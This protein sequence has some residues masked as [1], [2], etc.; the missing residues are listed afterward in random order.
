MSGFGD[1]IGI[2][3]E[4]AV[5]NSL[6]LSSKVS[7]RNLGIAMERK[8]GVP[9]KAIYVDD[10]KV[11]KRVFG[12]YDPNMYSPYVLECLFNN[13]GG[14][15]VS[16]YGL[17]ITGDGCEPAEATI[18]TSSHDT[19]T[20]TYAT[21]VAPDTGVKQKDMFTAANIEAGDEFT[22]SM[23]TTDL[24]YT[25]VIGDTPQTVANS[26]KLL[27]EAEKV[28]NPAGDFAAVNPLYGTGCMYLEADVADT[29][30]VATS[31]AADA[32]VVGAPVF[33]LTAGRMGEEDPGDWGNDLSYSFYPKGADGGLAN[34]YMLKIFYEDVLVEMWS[35]ATFAELDAQ[36]R[37]RSEYVIMDEIDYDT[38]ITVDIISGDLSG[39]IYVA[40]VEAD[41]EPDY[42]EA[43]DPVGMAIFEG[44]DVQIIFCPEIQSS[45][46]ALDAETWCKEKRKFFLHNLPYLATETQ[47]QDFYNALFTPDRSFQSG[48][49]NWCEVDDGE[50]GRIWI[51]AIGY[52][53]G[54]G[55]IRLAGMNDGRVWTPPGGLETRAYGV[56]RF[57]HDTLSDTTISR[58]VKQ[59][60]C[61]VVK[62][63]KN[64]GYCLWSSRTYSNNPL[65]QSVHIQ[66]EENWLGA[67][68]LLR[69]QRY[70]QKLGQPSTLR[71]MRLDDLTF[72]QFIYN[73]GGIEQSISFDQAV[74][75][76][77][78][79]DPTDRKQVE[80]D[81]AWIPPECIEH[82][83]I[84]L[85]RNDGILVLK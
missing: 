83:H 19:Q 82:I 7:T 32:G 59:F 75:I 40:P 31:A 60:A 77:V 55:Y 27:V 10:L 15:G 80:M 58:Y 70:V 11:D 23:G 65:F 35:A 81:I 44:Y 53:V 13:L 48:I 39:G 46:F 20:F 67:E 72:M 14:Y 37:Q 18:T 73:Q 56:Y 25:A 63:I 66:L 49:L 85:G 4:T 28:A 45:D 6:N 42:D 30:F 79:V 34:E 61:N 78:T 24:T 57:T 2:T 38:D 54:A 84:K 36:I 50:G 33:T 52:A 8:R 62:Y 71:E 74:V 12:G 1:Q 3:L 5:F 21:V 26:I 76:T 29:P 69:N 68:L 51:P 9:N 16:I 22:I 47:V 17:R 64:V 43:G 41:F